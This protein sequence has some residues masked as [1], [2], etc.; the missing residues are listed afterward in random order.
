MSVA[1]QRATAAAT[2]FDPYALKMTRLRHA[3]TSSPASLP[4]VVRQTIIEGRNIS[5]PLGSFV[6]KVAEHAYQITDDDV[7]ALHAANYNDDEIFEA[8]VSAALGAGLFRL[9][10]VLRA[11]AVSQSTTKEKPLTARAGR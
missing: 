8:T 1:A 4:A 2:A 7:A 3:V 6:R 10:C 5:G 9:E 11:F